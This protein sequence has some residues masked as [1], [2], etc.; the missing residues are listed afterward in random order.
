MSHNPDDFCTNCG[1]TGHSR[2][3]CPWPRP[4]EEAARAR[5]AAGGPACM[6]G[7]CTERDTCPQHLTDDREHV[8]ERVCKPSVDPL[9]FV[10]VAS[11][12]NRSGRVM[13]GAAEVVQ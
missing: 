12:L 13:R 1:G 4:G 11:F 6:G 10:P 9:P 5:L 7:W 8:V 3:E 2:S